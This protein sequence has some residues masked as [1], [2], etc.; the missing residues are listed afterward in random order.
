MRH[1][2]KPASVAQPEALKS[3]ALLTAIIAWS[4]STLSTQWTFLRQEQSWADLESTRS[5]WW[6]ITRN[7][8][9][10]RSVAAP[11]ATAGFPPG[12]TRSR[13]S[14]SPP[15]NHSGAATRADHRLL[16]PKSISLAASRVRR[17]LTTKLFRTNP[18]KSPEEADEKS[19]RC[20]QCEICPRLTPLRAPVKPRSKWS[21]W[22]LTE[23][24]KLL[25]CTNRSL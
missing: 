17:Q 13:A 5:R 9:W 2:P 24:T 21:K 10:A 7:G 3:Q 25:K 22:A 20:S 8:C 16:A 23:S 12:R 14:I 18:E 11:K 6:T 15:I 1:C 19:Q 4:A